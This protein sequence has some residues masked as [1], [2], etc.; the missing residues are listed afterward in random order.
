MV[1]SEP[2]MAEI[3]PPTAEMQINAAHTTH[4]RQYG[5]QPM[6]QMGSVIGCGPLVHS[7]RY[8]PLPRWRRMFRWRQASRWRRMFRWRRMS[9]SRW[10]LELAHEPRRRQSAA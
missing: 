3:E 1:E 5:I 4:A 10:R 2:P 9:R 6:A 8:V 7:M